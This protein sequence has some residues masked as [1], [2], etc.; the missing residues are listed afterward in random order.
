[1]ASESSLNMI[2]N[3]LY[4]TLKYLFVLKIFKL[5]SWLFG[6]VSKFI[7]SQPG[8]QTIAINIFSYTQRSKDN[9]TIEF[10]QLIEYNMRNIF[11]EKSFT[12]CGGETI[13]RPFSKIEQIS[14]SIV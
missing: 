8:S 4:L 3:T 2:K 6:H 11:L 5:L 7:T 12:K 14:G 9:Q 1:M 13:P 10:G